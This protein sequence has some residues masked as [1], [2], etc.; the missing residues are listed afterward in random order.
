MLTELRE[1]MESRWPLLSHN[2]NPKR[3]TNPSKKRLIISNDQPSSLEKKE[4][5]SDPGLKAKLKK[6]A[7]VNPS[8]LNVIKPNNI[9]SSKNQANQVGPNLKLRLKEAYNNYSKLRFSPTLTNSNHDQKCNNFSPMQNGKSLPQLKCNNLTNTAIDNNHKQ[10]SRNSAHKL[11]FSRPSSNMK[12]SFSASIKIKNDITCSS[13]E[14]QQNHY[15]STATNEIKSGVC[16]KVRPASTSNMP[17]SKM[18]S[19]QFQVKAA[20]NEKSKQA[21]MKNSEV[22]KKIKNC[23]S[24]DL[25]CLLSFSYD[26][27]YNT[28]NRIKNE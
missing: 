26:E 27:F 11:N 1:F 18:K 22:I 7:W 17:N 13:N 21:S 28:T 8:K 5:A 12:E 3:V 24:S 15:L 25:Q 4:E 20:V 6:V 23:I 2:S 16:F 19:R 14:K 9:T 10:F